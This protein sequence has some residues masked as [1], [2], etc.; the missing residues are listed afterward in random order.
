MLRAKAATSPVEELLEGRYHRVLGDSTVKDAERVLVC[1]GKIVHEL[2]E[3]RSRRGA[4]RTAI[5]SLEDLYPFPKESL[6]AELKRHA[7]ARQIIWVQEEPANKGAR[8]FVRPE[9]EQLADGRRVTTV[10]RSASASPA[11]GSAKAHKLEQ[12]TL[13]ELAFR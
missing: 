1:S 9:I 11:T 12:Q 10:K 4:D 6:R 5:V 2:L 13:L 7:N 3:E 8:T